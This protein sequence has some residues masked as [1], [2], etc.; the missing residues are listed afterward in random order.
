M[1]RCHAQRE[2]TH[3]YTLKATI[4]NKHKHVTLHLLIPVVNI[5][6]TQSPA[7]QRNTGFNTWWETASQ[8]LVWL[9][10]EIEICKKN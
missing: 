3:V 6:K 2:F 5:L 10:M 4:L 1:F 9:C 8:T 7:Q